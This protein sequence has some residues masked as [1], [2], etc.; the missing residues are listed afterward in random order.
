MTLNHLH[1]L[2]WR[3]S[4]YSNGQANC[5]EIANAW[6]DVA[7]RDSKDPDGPALVYTR[8]A[9]AAFVAGVK[10]GEFSDLG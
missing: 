2:T 6:P 10:S 1:D 4:S 9:M 3:K 8:A 7:V 5:V